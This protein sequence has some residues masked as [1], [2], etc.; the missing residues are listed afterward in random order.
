MND[1]LLRTRKKIRFWSGIIKNLP[2][3]TKT[4]CRWKMTYCQ[5]AMGRMEKNSAWKKVSLVVD[6]YSK[7]N[8]IQGMHWSRFV[9]GSFQMMVRFLLFLCW[10]FTLLLFL[11]WAFALLLFLFLFFIFIFRYFV[12]II[13]E[14]LH[15][16]WIKSLVKLWKYFNWLRL[17]NL[18]QKWLTKT[19]F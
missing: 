16:F 15:K 7:W 12:W 5:M 3:V 19:H 18:G 10:A 17:A 14:N 2:L 11:G 8:F 6:G 1:Q 13:R 9:I 4:N